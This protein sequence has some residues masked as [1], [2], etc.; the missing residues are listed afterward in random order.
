M[1]RSRAALERSA[2]RHGRGLRLG[3][4][5]F[6]SVGIAT[7]Q[8]ARL[9]VNIAAAGVLGPSVFG[10]WVLLTLIL[11]YASFATL[12]LPN[13]A[14]REV[15]VRLGA[16]RPNDAALVEDVTLGGTLVAAL[17][18][19]SL[20]IIVVLAMMD[21]SDPDRF[22]IALLLG[23]AVASQQVYLLMQVFFRSRF[24]FR[25]VA[26]QMGLAGVVVLVSGLTLLPLGVAGLSASVVLGHAT[27]LLAGARLLP[28]RPRPRWD[29]AESRRLI[30]IGFPIMLAGFAFI[31]L[32]TADRWLVLAFLGREAV[33]VYGL[34][35]MM[36]S[37]L[38][39]VASVAGQQYFPR[40]AFAFGAGEGGHELASIARSQ[41]RVTAVA[42]AAIALPTV[43]GAWIAVTYLLPAYHEA[44]I[45]LTIMSAGILA[46]AASSGF[47]NLLN[48]VG[49][50][51]E[52]LTLQLLAVAVDVI[53]VA[54]A[55]AVGGRL[56]GVAVAT[57][58]TFGAYAYA[59][60]RRAIAIAGSIPAAAGRTD[61]PDLHAAPGTG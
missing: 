59:L 28:R 40:M 57:A 14:G 19:A 11:Q 49:H 20:A 23:L 4:S 29:P 21:T 6:L 26:G 36:V 54:C 30:S 56:L 31:L 61:S 53:L 16:D 24:A 27:A 9:V 46:Y 41:G 35:G 45:P 44:L 33:G 7:Y 51:R 1:N 38:L 25:A 3:D 43:A 50:H 8:A 58:L 48:V 13:A 47:G 34:V 17:T 18:G 12:G 32:T 39:L 52:Y 2:A 60:R 42:M 37:G 15:P 5:A 22:V 10:Q 55:L